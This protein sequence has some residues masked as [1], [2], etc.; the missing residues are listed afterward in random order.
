MQSSFHPRFSFAIPQ[1][2]RP[3]GGFDHRRFKKIDWPDTAA[4]DEGASRAAAGSA[5]NGAPE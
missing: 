4:G 1:N 2:E 5:A 3:V